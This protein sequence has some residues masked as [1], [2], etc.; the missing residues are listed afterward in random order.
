MPSLISSAPLR[1]V[2]EYLRTSYPEGDLEYDNGVLVERNVGSTPHSFLQLIVGEHLRLFRK[3]HR[4]G[5]LIGCRTR[6]S[7]SRFRVPDVMVVPEPYDR[8]A[9][10]YDGV[11]LVVIEILSPEDRIKD[12]LI[13]FADYKALGSR[14]ILLMDPEDH[15]TY[16]Y[17]SGSLSRQEL[18]QLGEGTDAIPFDTQALYAAIDD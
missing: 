10:Y 2:E 11:P 8:K 7:P 13:R 1:S 18:K 6:I 5:V 9:S 12:A 15:T 17:E 4:F 3:S 16:V 14:F